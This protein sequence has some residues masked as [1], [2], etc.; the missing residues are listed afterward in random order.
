M[1]MNEIH[2]LYD[3]ELEKRYRFLE[4]ING[5]VKDPAGYDTKTIFLKE[6]VNGL[7]K[8][9]RKKEVFEKRVRGGA[10]K[11]KHVLRRDRAKISFIKGKLY[12]KPI[13]PK[14]GREDVFVLDYLRKMIGLRKKLVKDD[15]FL[16]RNLE[17]VAK[18]FKIVVTENYMKKIKYYLE[19]HVIGFGL[20][21][22]LFDDPDVKGI[23]CNGVEKK[24]FVDYKDKINVLT[25]IFFDNFNE[26][27]RV[28][29]RFGELVDV[30]L[31]RENPVLNVELIDGTVIQAMFGDGSISPKFV[32]KRG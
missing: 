18:K 14:L 15:I 1:M 8:A 29:S 31:S 30:K 2:F 24:V 7:I 26:L 4:E 32:V 16:R 5:V 6:F 22:P 20:V 9:A 3:E 28:V 11:A 23:Y 19:K 27:N 17:S 25:E 10:L 13:E 12:Y 21:Q